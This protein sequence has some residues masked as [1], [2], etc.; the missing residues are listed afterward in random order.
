MGLP[1]SAGEGLLG[2]VV[3]AVVAG[4]LLPNSEVAGVVSAGFGLGSVLAVFA[5]KRVA[6]AGLEAAGTVVFPKRLVGLVLALVTGVVVVFVAGAGSVV[7]L[8]PN[9]LVGGAEVAVVA[10]GALVATGFTVS[11]GFVGWVPPNKLGPLVLAVLAVTPNILVVGWAGVLAAVA[12]L[13]VVPNML[14]AGCA[15]VL[16]L[17]LF[18]NK[19][20]PMPVAGLAPNKLEALPCAGGLLLVVAA[21]AV[22]LN[23][24]LVGAVLFGW[25]VPKRLV[26][27][28]PPKRPVP[29]LPVLP[30]VLGWLLKTLLLL[31][32]LGLP[33][34]MIL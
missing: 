34:C 19:E 21:G 6:G 2:V 23:R 10:A 3:A 12:L 14:V 16:A 13:T 8:L 7:D 28:C 11:A 17:L 33:N 20:L 4:L 30:V 27:F 32:G 25:A 31:V 18:P 5:P 15:G 9:R 22:L 26:L 29:A 24:L 1:K